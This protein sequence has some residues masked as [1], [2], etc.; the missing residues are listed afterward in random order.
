MAG[1]NRPTGGWN[2][3]FDG[4]DTLE[5]PDALEPTRYPYARNIRGLADRRVQTRPGYTLFSTAPGIV[6]STCPLPSATQSTGYSTT[7]SAT[8]GIPPYTWSLFSGTLPGGLSIASNGVVSGTPTQSGLFNF[9]IKVVD[10]V[11]GT[12]IAQCSIYVCP[13]G[14]GNSDWSGCMAGS[15]T[16]PGDWTSVGGCTVS[17]GQGHNT[18]F[19]ICYK[20]ANTCGVSLRQEV[21]LNYNAVVSGG[22]GNVGYNECGPGV[23]MSGSILGNISGYFFTAIFFNTGTGTLGVCGG[24][25]IVLR[26]RKARLGAVSTLATTAISGP[27]LASGI[28]FDIQCVDSGSNAVI[29]AYLGGT[30]ML[31]FTDT[32]NVLGAGAMG[33]GYLDTCGGVNPADVLFAFIKGQL[34]P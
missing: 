19:G 22:V 16:V 34:L 33:W 9:A 26:L 10:A 8:G 14:Q 24:P 31:T 12:D 21:Y 32:T 29:T 4:M 30:Q 15:F 2:Y 23:R 11:G 13:L 25:S 17:G 3:V 18:S 5:A 1:Y 28:P 7:L 27:Q 6:P 20:N